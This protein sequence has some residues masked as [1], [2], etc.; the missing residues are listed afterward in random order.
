MSPERSA[1]LGHRVHFS[2]EVLDPDREGRGF[3]GKVVD[4]TIGVRLQGYE[5]SNLRDGDTLASTSRSARRRL[6]W[7]V[8]L[9][10]AVMARSWAPSR[11]VLWSRSSTRGAVSSWA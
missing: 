8:W 5:V 1:N 4:A 11:S 2:P 9:M 3:R 7:V 6:A 10:S